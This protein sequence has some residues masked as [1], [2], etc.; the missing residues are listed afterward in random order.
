VL[1]FIFTI[2]IGIGLIGFATVIRRIAI[3]I[4]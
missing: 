4:N 2:I 3:G 1:L